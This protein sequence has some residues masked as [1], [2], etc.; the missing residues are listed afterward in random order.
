MNHKASLLLGTLLGLA[1]STLQLRAAAIIWNGPLTS[2][3]KP[4]FGNPALAANQDRL[5][6][7][8]WLTR[9]SSQGLYNANTEPFFTH[10]SSPTGTQWA[11]GS[12]A[13]YSS[14][15][16]TDWNTWSKNISG[17]P[18]STIGINAV[19]H[20]MPDDIYLSV[21]FTSWTTGG[22]GGGFSYM[23]S[24]PVVPEPSSALLVIGGLAVFCA[25][26]RR[27]S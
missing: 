14:L 13:N 25:A 10:Y 26:R 7:N 11:T 16:Y 22:S 12:L 24:T 4:N 8:I 5:T 6:S 19:V 27:R 20:L 1:A 9:G 17:G 15:S 2:F 21:R 18:P 3:T 23:R